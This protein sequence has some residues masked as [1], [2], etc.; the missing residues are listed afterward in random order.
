MAPHV[1]KAL[2]QAHEQRAP[3][4]VDAEHSDRLGTEQPLAVAQAPR[5]LSS[6]ATDDFAIETPTRG[7][8]GTLHIRR[9]PVLRADDF[10]TDELRRTVEQ[11]PGADTQHERPQVEEDDFVRGLNF[12]SRRG[13]SGTWKVG[14]INLSPTPSGATD[15]PEPLEEGL[16]ALQWVARGNAQYR[17]GVLAGARRCYDAALRA[18]STCAPAYNNRGNLR[19]QLGDYEGAIADY[20]MAIEL[21]PEYVDAYSNR[22]NAHKARGNVAGAIADYDMAISLDPT[23]AFAFN[24]RGNARADLNDTAGALDDFSE[25]LRIDPSYEVA[26]NNRGVVHRALGDLDAALQ[27]YDAAIAINPLYAT[28]YSNRGDAHLKRGCARLAV[29]D[30]QRYLGLGGGI[31]SGDHEK[32]EA[33]IR[34]VQQ[35]AASTEEDPR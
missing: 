22:G 2:R 11:F 30:Y 1:T 32:V 10:A 12:R 18:D 21:N 7:A 5:R 24:N 20:D 25:A 15:A 27:D 16:A 6:H 29:Q 31:L 9:A 35:L 8:A 28:A 4:L 3:S 19:Y 33:L 26:W 14:G 34:L 23:S 13:D 17:H